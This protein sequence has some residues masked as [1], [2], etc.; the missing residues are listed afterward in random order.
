MKFV[1]VGQQDG[2]PQRHFQ[3]ITD[4]LRDGPFVDGAEGRDFGIV[5]R[6][7]RYRVPNGE[8][9]ELPAGLTIPLGLVGL[10][11]ARQRQVQRCPIII[12]Q[13]MMANK[14]LNALGAI[15]AGQ[16]KPGDGPDRS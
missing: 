11:K 2:R 14:G 13:L 3:R 10:A 4:G 16:A 12:E 7:Y 15:V 5:P 1:D 9:L 8:V 6:R